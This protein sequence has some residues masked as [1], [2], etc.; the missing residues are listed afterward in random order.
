MRKFTPILLAA[1]LIVGL[2]ALAPAPAQA[3]DWCF[4]CDQSPECMSCCMCEFMSVGICGPLCGS[5]DEPVI[6]QITFGD[7]AVDCA[8]EEAPVSDEAP[9]ADQAAKMEEAPSTEEAAP[10]VTE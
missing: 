4:L 8:V 10:A 5:P 6:P 7:E 1:A 2:A 9:N 3:V